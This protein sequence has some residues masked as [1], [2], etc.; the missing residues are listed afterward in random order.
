MIELAVF[1]C[2]IIIGLSV[3][4]V[5]A[6]ELVRR[7]RS[8]LGL[9]G[10][11]AAQPPASRESPASSPAERV[12]PL[13]AP[14]DKEF[15][16][17][18]HP[19]DLA[20]YPAF[21]DVVKLLA[22]PALPLEAVL[23]Y[24]T[25]SNVALSCAAFAAI[26]VR[27]DVDAAAPK[28]IGMVGNVGLWPLHH[29]LHAIASAKRPW[30]LGV[31][32]AR[33]RTWWADNSMAHASVR[34]YLDEAGRAGAAAGFGGALS[35]RLDLPAIHAV[36]TR[37]AH[38]AT[39]ALL[40]E[41]NHWRLTTV[42]RDALAGVG[43]FWASS[44]VD[45]P[46]VE[47]DFLRQPLVMAQAAITATPPACLLIVGE[48]RVG[49]SSLIRLLGLK[50]AAEGYALFEAGA[51][52]IMAGQK[53][54]GEIEER[55][56]LLMRE[57]QTAKR[58]LW[59]VPDI[60]AMVSAGVHQGQSASIL[61]Q[62]LPAIAAHELLIVG[63]A[64]PETLVR[65]TQLKPAT[66]TAF[67]TIRIPVPSAAEMET[68]TRAFGAALAA[69]AHIDIGTGA[70]EAAMQLSKQYL[71]AD[72]GT[73]AALDLLKLA[74]A[75][76]ASLEGAVL[77][78]SALLQT[79]SEASGLPVAILDEGEAIE[80]AAVR[81]FFDA[82]VMGQPAAVEAVVGRIAMLKAGLTDPSRPIGVFLF[83]GPT[84]TGKTELA[85]TLAGY[86]FG[87]AERL[88]R[89]DMSDSRLRRRRARFSVSRGPA[90]CA[91]RP[92]S[93]S[94][95]VS[96]NSRSR[97]CCSMNS[98]RRTPMCG[99]CSCRCSTTAGSRTPPDTRST[100][101]TPS[102]S[103]PPISAP[104]AIRARAWALRRRRAASTMRRCCARSR[105]PS[106]RSSST[107]WTGCWCSNRWGAT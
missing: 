103:S 35:P 86:L 101:A 93:R 61:D 56:R 26:A 78:R 100:S 3:A 64:T 69:A 85:K 58:V 43:R 13:I 47:F 91:A 44:T 40:A 77:D 51:A 23:Q 76:V 79:L 59:Y 55:V 29:A 105:R 60:L 17:C 39:A 38:P 18:A 102:S 107:G 4:G 41:F 67:Q 94:R 70:I 68:A 28:V 31:T 42:D 97:S 84:G 73:G 7:A 57:L 96:A 53:Y 99:I 87:G 92:P 80:L 9:R 16:A 11:A 20:L 22:D 95:D 63:E 34:G 48:P 65:L 49:K 12:Q 52:D 74:A 54:I 83:A 88:V 37:I 72:R 6:R 24:G 19:S 10:K 30:P 71:G 50:L 75:R 62:I 15:A 33:A 32:L 5:S 14:L 89:L 8:L 90:D 27:P 36:L 66:R 46:L 21:R 106:A 25:G 104:P 81:R 82:R 98:R 1:V 2:G 45:S